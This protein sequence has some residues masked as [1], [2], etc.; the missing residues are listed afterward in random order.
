MLVEEKGMS[1][2]QFEQLAAEEASRLPA[3]R[4]AAAAAARGDGAGAGGGSFSVEDL[5]L[6]ERSFWANITMNPPL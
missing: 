3:Y 4:Q 5:E 6:S 2:T 1:V